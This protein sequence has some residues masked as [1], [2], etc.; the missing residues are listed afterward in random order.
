[1]RLPETVSTPIWGEREPTA[2]LINLHV[3]WNVR[4][5]RPTRVEAFAA[6]S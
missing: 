5:I 3:N 6:G 1:M 2:S 4:G